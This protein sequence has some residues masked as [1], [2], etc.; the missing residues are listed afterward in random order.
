MRPPTKIYAAA[1]TT[2]LLTVILS[3]L[4]L[5]LAA[6]FKRSDEFAIHRALFF[7]AFALNITAL[8]CVLY[9]AVVATR[10][11]GSKSLRIAWLDPSLGAGY[12]TVVVLVNGG[13]LI[14]L[15]DMRHDL[16]SPSIALPVAALIIWIATLISQVAFFIL[17]STLSRNAMQAII[18]S[19]P[20]TTFGIILPASKELAFGSRPSFCSRDTTLVSQPQ[21]PA[22]A[23]TH[24]MISSTTKGATSLRSKLTHHSL[25]SSLD[26]PA[27][28]AGE[29]TALGSS[30]DR[31]NTSQIDP[32]SRN[33]NTLCAS[34]NYSRTTHCLESIPGSR[35]GS[36]DNIPAIP[37]NNK[38]AV[39]P[40]ETRSSSAASSSFRTSRSSSRAR[41]GSSPLPVPG[42]INEHIHPLFRPNSPKPPQ[43]MSSNTMVIASPLANQPMTP[44]SL[45]RLRSSSDLRG[46]AS[47]TEPGSLVLSTRGQWRVMPSVES[48]PVQARA[49]PHS[50]LSCTKSDTIES[51]V[52]D[53]KPARSEMG[54]PGPSIMEEDELPPILPGFI[55]SAGT[56]SS[57]VG[58]DKRK[59]V[60]RDSSRL[61]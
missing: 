9:Y 55:L 31:F 10:R 11:L 6:Q 14:W 41:T 52:D 23:R 25:R 32:E 59:S 49:R 45:E 58:Y 57:L 16:P 5:L 50:M 46:K 56:R 22:S 36:S 54:S 44:R 27:F 21:S 39:N 43:I 8:G 37:S 47:S 29:A 34:P 20:V 61:G 53:Q 15:L 4:V 48:V 17:L 51:N 19:D 24:S 26:L 28:P 13:A 60:K 2:V 38:L 40:F 33:T 3:T 18:H 1:S 42:S 7:A 12:T 30:F 35:P